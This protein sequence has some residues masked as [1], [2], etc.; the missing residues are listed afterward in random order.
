MTIRL[1]NLKIGALI[2]GL[3]FVYDIFMVFVSPLI[4]GGKSV[5]LQV[6]TAGKGTQTVVSHECERV[7]EE[8]MPM[9]FLV[10]RFSWLGHGTY[11]MLGLGD[12]VFPGLL[13]TM[14]LRYD[15]A[16]IARRG[17]PR[18]WQNSRLQAFLGFDFFGYFPA[19]VLAYAGGLI[20][21]FAALLL[22]F[23]IFNVKGQPALL[24]LVP[25]TVGTFAAVAKC[26]GEL[27]DVWNVKWSEENGAIPLR[28]MGSEPGT[29]DLP[30]SPNSFD[31]PHQVPTLERRKSSSSR[32]AMGG[33]SGNAPL[34][35]SDGMA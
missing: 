20:T 27:S 12:V 24:Y 21:T 28:R 35:S 9:L 3:F 6:A 15:Y 26:R 32:G 14:A 22:D 2:L 11:S 29:P 34:L 23:T 19:L 31:A 25:F 30:R 5:M 10:P 18:K 17:G 7:Q 1:P 16:E 13:V 33:D 4:F 8:R